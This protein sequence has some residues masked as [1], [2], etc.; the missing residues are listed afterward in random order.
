MR[1]R[2]K[3]GP[4]KRA[5]AWLLSV[6]V[7]F[8]AVPVL[9]AGSIAVRAEESG[10][11]GRAVVVYLDSPSLNGA[12]AKDADALRTI[13][14]STNEFE[15]SGVEIY[16]LPED[17]D[18]DYKSALWEKMD[19]IAEGTDENSYTVFS[20]VGHGSQE[21]DGTSYLAGGGANNIT[22]AELRTHLDKLQGKV[23]VLLSCCY[24]G[25]MILPAS[26]GADAE[27]TAAVSAEEFGEE[28]LEA[29]ENAEVPAA[30]ENAQPQYYFITTGNQLETG[31]S[32][33]VIGTETI[34][35]FGHAM[36]YDRNNDNYHVFAADTTTLPGTESRSGYA[37]DGRITMQELADYYKKTN[38]ITSSPTVY[39]EDST[40]VLFT[41][42]EEAGTPATLSC[43]I[44][45]ENMSV[46]EKGVIKFTATVQNLTDH[47]IEVGTGVYDLGSRTF[48]LTTASRGKY[49]NGESLDGYIEADGTYT[50]EAGSTDTVNY[51]FIWDEFRDGASN[52]KENPFA[53]K[54]WDCTDTGE[55]IGT[56]RL[57]SFYTRPE[58]A[59]PDAIDPD[60]LCLRKPAQLT[61]NENKED[62]EGTGTEEDKGDTE[63]TGT[64]GD[65]EDAVPDAVT[66]TSSRLPVEIVYDTQT[67]SKS[68]NAACTLSLYAY[69][70]GTQLP[71]GIHVEKDEEGYSDVLKKAGG[72]EI[73]LSDDARTTVFENVRPTHDRIGD[74]DLRGSVHTYV[75]DTSELSLQH[76]YAVRAVCH[77]DATGKEKSVYALILRTEAKDAEQYQI[78]FVE[79]SDDTWDWFRYRDG[80]TVGESWSD[81]KEEYRTVVGVGKE[82]QEALNRSST[83]LYSFDVMGWEVLDESGEWRSAED[84]EMFKAGGTYRCLIEVTVGDGYNAVFTKE[85]KVRTDR[86]E[87]EQ[88]AVIN[89]RKLDLQVV[90]KVPDASALAGM[91][92]EMYR[93]DAV[94]ERIAAD[95]E[96]LHPG[97]K[98]ILV[99]GEDCRF[100]LREGLEKT[101]ESVKKDGVWYDVYKV[102]DF[103]KGTNSATLGVRVWKSSDDNCGCTEVLYRWTAHLNAEGGDDGGKVSPGG[104][105]GAAG[106]ADAKDESTSASARAAGAAETAGGQA[107][108]T[109]PAVSAASGEEVQKA[110]AGTGAAGEMRA[111]DPASRAAATTGDRAR[112]GL[113]LLLGLSSGVCGV[114]AAVCRKRKKQ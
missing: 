24:A 100:N 27:D 36:G 38:M 103:Q 40:E 69:D 2:N 4:A 84:T 18:D 1:D 104:G 41:Y 12:P 113:W 34:A 49:P 10:E 96:S 110:A 108:V 68:T 3:K 9:P 90:H 107:N 72:E 67:Q 60:A 71:D 42:T 52:E 76:Y 85:T 20:Y 50:V 109:S 35:A 62:A 78:P 17:S 59:S 82:L 98:V 19:A 53:L 29:F 32:H 63:G 93:A 65:E 61:V 97:D 87:L 86:H 102:S 39:P 16:K 75:W 48:A 95:N 64:D 111:A 15:E 81:I 47:D 30:A 70:L 7:A 79:I 101:G 5:A 89:S 91:T 114:I 112:P 92:L 54:I 22:A 106:G 25:G 28:F 8:T 46:D 105:D 33:S 23:L 56:Y 77:D 11:S 80:F 45:Q 73:S 43:S 99:P 37:G 26:E 57:L 88:F 66:K 44:P 83:G 58:E 21:K 31:Y 51:E 6:G 94:N 55:Q 14:G 74:V 13:L